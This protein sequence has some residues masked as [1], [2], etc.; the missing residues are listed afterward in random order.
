[1]SSNV[2]PNVARSGSLESF[3]PY[4]LPQKV[5]K[6]PKIECIHSGLPKNAKSHFGY[7]GPLGVKTDRLPILG[8]KCKGNQ[9]L[10]LPR[11]PKRVMENRPIHFLGDG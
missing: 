10:V 3:H 5:S 1:M 9:G 7:L 6:I 11:P 8:F 4:I 2:N